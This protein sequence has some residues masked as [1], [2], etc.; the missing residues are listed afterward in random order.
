MPNHAENDLTVTGPTKDV[1]AF[2]EFARGREIGST[3]DEPIHFS[4]FIPYPSQYQL[5]DL[6]KRLWEK[7]HPGRFAPIVDGFN[8]GGYEWCN[9]NWGTKWSA[10][11]FSAPK[12]SKMKRGSKWK[13]TFNT[14]WSPPTPVI[15]AMS[16]RFP[17][18]RFCLRTY[19]RGMAYKFHL[20]VKGGLQL[21]ENT[22][23][24]HGRRGG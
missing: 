10:Y 11:S 19:E 7:T 1:K 20:V 6:Y 2:V 13:I 16:K 3:E 14:A 23:K 4:R 8:S 17:S 18:L 22:S 9:A 5:R 21:L 15:Y 24:Y 12:I